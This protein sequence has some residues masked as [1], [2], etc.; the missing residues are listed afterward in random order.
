MKMPF[1]LFI[2]N[3]VKDFQP[4]AVNINHSLFLPS[5]S[6]ISLSLVQD[7]EFPF[8]SYGSSGKILPSF[9]PSISTF[10]EFKPSPPAMIIELSTNI[11]R[12]VWK[13]C[14]NKTYRCTYIFET[15]LNPQQ[16]STS[17]LL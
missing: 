10:L 9:C 6:Q 14:N 7:S 12:K 17:N 5:R 1:C 16:L 2:R 13:I 8:V 15:T 11:E 3:F 4:L